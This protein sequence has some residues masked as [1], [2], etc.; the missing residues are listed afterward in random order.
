MPTTPQPRFQPPSPERRRKRRALAALRDPR[1]AGTALGAAV[2]EAAGLGVWTVLGALDSTEEGA[3]SEPAPSDSLD[4]FDELRQA[5]EAAAG[6]AAAGAPD[7]GAS[8]EAAA[9]GDGFS[10]LRSAIERSQA[11]AEDQPLGVPNSP[12][13]VTPS[14]A[15]SSAPPPAAPAAGSEAPAAPDPA[16]APVAETPAPPSAESPAAPVGEAP[17]PPVAAPVT[18]T[19]DSGAA[20]AAEPGGMAMTTPC[21]FTGAASTGLLGATQLGRWPRSLN[22][23]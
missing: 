20:P 3:A 15:T 14:D 17:A 18:P 21:Q 12:F 13:G 7:G 5:S 6:Q 2:S 23:S 10:I 11:A 16:P 19:E 22:D 8:G 4:V 9:D 1:L